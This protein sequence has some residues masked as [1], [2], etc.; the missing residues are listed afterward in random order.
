MSNYIYDEILEYSLEQG[1]MNNDI[2]T[3]YRDDTWELGFKYNELFQGTYME[4]LEHVT[5]H[6]MDRGYLF[7]ECPNGVERYLKA[8]DFLGVGNSTPEGGFPPLL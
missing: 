6:G 8:E 4:C 5:D 3:L 1:K 7:V 2:F